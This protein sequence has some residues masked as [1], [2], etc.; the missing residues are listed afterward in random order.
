MWDWQR[1][2]ATIPFP[3]SSLGTQ[4]A[5]VA[6]DLDPR[7]NAAL[8]LRSFSSVSPSSFIAHSTV[9]FA[10]LWRTKRK[11]ARFDLALLRA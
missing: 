3:P 2:D 5:L 4:D 8:R 11:E 10:S 1:S 7:G 9:S 6:F